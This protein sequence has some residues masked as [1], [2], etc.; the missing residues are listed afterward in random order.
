VHE[1]V[2]NNINTLNDVDIF[3]VVHEIDLSCVE[4]GAEIFALFHFI[5]FL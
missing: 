3:L 1:L 2:L 5:Y 4:G